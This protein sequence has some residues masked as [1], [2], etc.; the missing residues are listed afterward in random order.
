[1]KTILNKVEK[2]SLRHNYFYVTLITSCLGLV[3]INH[4]EKESRFLKIAFLIHP[5]LLFA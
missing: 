2:A 4:I 1:M 5:T 3:S